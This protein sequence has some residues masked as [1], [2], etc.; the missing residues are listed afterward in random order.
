M[1]HSFPCGSPPLDFVG[2]L[3][4]RRSATPTEQL[5]SPAALDA[6]FVESG[7]LDASP[8]TSG[9]DLE[10]AVALRE[11]AYA[12]V[13]ARIAG[14]EPPSAALELVN[15]R[16]LELPVELRLG[17]DG[18][19]RTGTVAQGLASLARE[20]VAI[21]GGDDGALLR[22]CGRPECTQVY[23]DRSRGHRREWCSMR[24]CGNRVKA[25]TF[26]ARQRAL[27]D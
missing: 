5:S 24:T 23:V 12:L 3:Q 7:M 10:A 9:H 18:L 26:R 16:A 8:G 15:S 2:T 27:A 21:L 1:L 6:W 14:D 17:A 4:A 19:R 20:L 13:A 25:S 22:E 11:A